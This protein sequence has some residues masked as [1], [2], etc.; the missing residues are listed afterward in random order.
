MKSDDAVNVVAMAV[1]G[2][3][4][5]AKIIAKAHIDKA[6]L[7]FSRLN[8][9]SFNRRWTEAT[10]TANK[11]KYTLGKDIFTDFS[12][13]QKIQYF[14]RTDVVGW[15]ITVVSIEEF[16]QHS[17]GYTT[18]GAPVLATIHSDSGILEF[19][20]TPDSAYTV[21]AYLK[22]QI[23][24]FEDIDDAYH[25]VVID[26]AIMSVF[27][28]KDAGTAAM[29]LREG[30]DDIKRD[31]RVGWAGGGISINRHLGPDG[32][33]GYNKADSANPTGR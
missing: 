14:W 23:T 1:G 7:K 33:P 27:A 11:E 21:A 25:D 31:S 10:L 19:Y 32:G 18:T 30:F 28:T 24:K 15:P 2:D 26:Y 3:A 20:P 6:V 13:I 12:D 29:M 5:T 9:V 17:S 4:V 16:Q 22:R 8:N